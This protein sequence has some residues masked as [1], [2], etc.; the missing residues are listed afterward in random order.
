MSARPIVHVHHL[1]DTLATGGAETL[2]AE[3]TRVAGDQG[4]HITVGYLQDRAGGAAHERLLAAQDEV[5]LVGIP[6]RLGPTALWRTRT[7]LAAVAPDILHTH[8]GYSDLLG[9]LAAR[10]LGLP[11]VSTVHQEVWHDGTAK[12]RLRARL[13]AHSRR[14][15]TQRVIAVS[16][17]TRAAYLATGWDRPDRVVTIRNGVAGRAQ[18]GAGVRI[19]Q[20][21][22]LRPGALVVGTLSAL[23]P[24]K[25][26]DVAIAA[27]GMLLDEYPSLRLVIPGDGPH[28][29]AVQVLAERLGDRVVLAGSRVDVMS[30]LDAYDVLLHPSRPGAEALPTACLEAMA[31]SVPVVA[32]DVGGTREVLAGGASGVLVPSGA[33]FV[34]V[35]AALSPLLDDP[36]RR[37]ALGE[38]GRRRFEAEFTA[39]RWAQRL[40]VLYREVLAEGR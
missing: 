2:L 20:E 3:L 29:E 34:E 17:P 14:A 4:L 40:G 5:K 25:S 23:R 35:A 15:G 18:P 12:S 27:V 10:S 8:L 9:C 28:R 6:G 21:L 16:E 13:T 33:G 30:L 37:R 26:H 11:A 22:A 36:Q 7:H 19:R 31:A 32:T 24:E 39:E 1:I 38:A